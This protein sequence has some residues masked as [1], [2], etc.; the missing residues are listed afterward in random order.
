MR[1]SR[2]ATTVIHQNLLFGMAFIMTFIILAALGYITPI[3][4][5][6]LHML[7]A[8]AVIFNS[9]RLVRFGEELHLSDAPRQPRQTKVRLEHVPAT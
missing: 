7:T 5:A 8:T 2:K 9:A 3:L 4:G 6:A 1:L